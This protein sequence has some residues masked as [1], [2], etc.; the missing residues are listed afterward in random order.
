ME[1]IVQKL[2]PKSRIKWEFALSIFLPGKVSQSELPLSLPK[3]PSYT[4]VTW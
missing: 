1:F 2:A 4:A 3:R